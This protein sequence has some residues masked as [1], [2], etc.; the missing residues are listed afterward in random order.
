MVHV[1]RKLMLDIGIFALS[2]V[3]CYYIIKWVLDALD[4]MSKRRKDAECSSLKLITRLKAEGKSLN[5]HEIMLTSDYIDKDDLKLRWTDIGGLD[6]VIGELKELVVLPFSRPDIFKSSSRLLRPPKGILLHGPPGCGKTL[7]ARIIAKESGASFINLKISSIVEKWY[8]ESQK[9][10]EALFSL[11]VK[12]SPCIIFID[13]IDSFLR[14]RTSTDH[15]AT[16][17][18][19]AQFMTLWDGLN[20]DRNDD[21]RVIIIGATN[22][23]LDV[24]KAILR[25]M[26]KAFHIGLP[27]KDQRKQILKVILQKEKLGACVD[28][29]QI[30]E[31]TEGYSGSKLEDLCQSAAFVSLREYMGK[32]NGSVPPSE[33]VE[34]RPLRLDDFLE[35]LKP[36]ALAPK[37]QV[38]EDKLD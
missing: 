8:G 18:M 21:T 12:L 9:L 10:V 28:L 38:Q 26:P 32:T 19:K 37:P 36:D 30:A 35:T 23:P 22:R 13:E 7:L 3:A 5:E 27:E 29:D 25:R 17:M 31:L 33:D 20:T 24:D 14:E 16:A 1:D 34:L 6:R 11:A 15:E 2:Q 4:P